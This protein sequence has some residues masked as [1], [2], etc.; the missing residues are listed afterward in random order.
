MPVGLQ[1]VGRRERD[2]HLLAVARW[3]ETRIAE[4][5]GP[6]PAAIRAKA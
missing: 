3:I 6:L 5:C 2:D 4:A 1:L